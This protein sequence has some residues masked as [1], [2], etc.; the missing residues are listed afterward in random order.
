MAN[1]LILNSMLKHSYNLLNSG[2]VIIDQE[3]SIL[4]MNRWVQN[5]MFPQ[6][7]H[8]RSFSDLYEKA[9]PASILRRF[10]T[11]LRSQT[12]SVFSSVI[13]QWLF[14][15][16]DHKFPDSQMRQ[17]CLVSPVLICHHNDEQEMCLMIQIQDV[18]N[19]ELQVTELKNAIQERVNAESKI[20]QLNQELELKIQDLAKSNKD[21]EQFAYVVSHDLQSP[22]RTINSFIELLNEDYEGQFDEEAKEYF[23]YIYEASSRMRSL[24]HAILSYSRINNGEPEI[25]EIT[26][27]DLLKDVLEDL[28]NDIEEN[29]AKFELESL[30]IIHGDIT[31]VSRLFQNLIG[32]AIKYRSELPPLIQ[33]RKK[34][35]G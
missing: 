32:N 10:R 16:Q 11:V 23:S 35:R 15:L 3:L 20:I 31:Q 1:T 13:H 2:I 26:L 8:A 4:F 30:P 27:N 6:H 5:R 34:R 9:P 14:P 18:S 7:I 12:P 22:L 19:M 29:Q 33:I 24:I 28:T 21:L 17:H 25:K